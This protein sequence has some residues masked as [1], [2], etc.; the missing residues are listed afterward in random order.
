MP[1][2]AGDCGITSA[3]GRG[4]APRRGGGGGRRV[5]AARR[6]GSRRCALSRG[7]LRPWLRA[8]GAKRRRGLL[9]AR[10][11]RRRARSSGG[12]A[13]RRGR[14]SG[15]SLRLRSHS[16]RSAGGL[17]A[18]RFDQRERRADRQGLALGGDE[19]RDHAGP[20][21][22]NFGI[23]LVGRNF[24]QR[25]VLLDAVALLDQP[26]GDGAFDHALAHLRHHYFD[27][28]AGPLRPSSKPRA[29]G[30]RRRSCWC[31]GGCIPP[32]VD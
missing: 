19:L 8:H 4:R 10:R 17:C 27:R 32:A 11:S 9:R 20:G 3:G 1:A 14:G 18:G 29:R 12:F 2:G 23:D 25:L 26:L 30:S 22:G 21:R 24:A 5:C 31:W 13:R 6:C 16:R 28:H 7:R 15:R